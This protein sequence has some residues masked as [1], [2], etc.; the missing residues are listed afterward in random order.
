MSGLGASEEEILA[1]ISTRRAA[2]AQLTDRRITMAHG[3]GGRASAALVEAL[4]L[5]ELD[6]P[7]LAGLDDA[8]PV[9]GAAGLVMTT[10]AFVVRPLRFPGGGIGELAVHGTVNDLAA[11]GAR[12][13]ALSAAFVL[14]EGLATAELAEQVGAMAAAARHCGVPIVAGDTKVVE[15]GRAEGCYVITTGIGRVELTGLAPGGCTQGDALLCSAPIA[16][17]GIAVL[18][19]RHE[20]AI[21]A[22]IVSDTRSLWPLVEPLVDLAGSIHALR[23]ATRGGVATVLNE[24]AVSSGV[25]AVVDEAALPVQAAVRGA[26]ELLGI[27]PLYVA[28]EGVLIAAVAAE[29][30]DEVLGRWR[31]VPAGEQAVRIGEIERRLAP[32]RVLV[33]T[34]VGGRRILD[35]LVGDPLPRIC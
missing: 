5:R 24:L 31:E 15:R 29:V 14:E 34:A 28:N 26:C 25:E 30:A 17:H 13:L 7:Q 21:D 22:P 9:P 3:A 19:A 16:A 35:T 20:L 18:T 4:F 33:D 6:N 11:C 1:R 32:G 27:D 8:S 23:D 2:P 12:P 10:D